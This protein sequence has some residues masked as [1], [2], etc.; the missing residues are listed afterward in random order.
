MLFNINKTNQAD[1][2]SW[3][4]ISCSLTW[5]FSDRASWIDYIH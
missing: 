5:Y 2:V 4:T 1:A 3:V